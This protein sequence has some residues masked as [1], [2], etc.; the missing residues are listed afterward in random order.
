MAEKLEVRDNR[1]CAKRCVNPGDQLEA[2]VA[3]IQA[4]DARAQTIEPASPFQ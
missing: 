2:S 1:H 4:D 3:Y